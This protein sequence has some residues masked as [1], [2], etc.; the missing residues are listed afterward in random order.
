MLLVVD[1]DPSLSPLWPQSNET[2][3]SLL[4]QLMLL[5]LCLHDFVLRKIIEELQAIAVMSPWKMELGWVSLG[6]DCYELKD[7]ARMV[8]ITQRSVVKMRQLAEV[9]QM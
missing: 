1:G 6:N 2:P 8:S 7:F 4:L 3:I 5:T 9:T